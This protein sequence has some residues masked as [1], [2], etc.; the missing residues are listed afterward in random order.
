MSGSTV[1]VG[2]PV[3]TVG[4]NLYQGAVYVY[5]Q[6]ASGWSGLMTPS[7]ELTASDGTARDDFGSSVAA[8]GNTIAAKGQSPNA[9]AVYVFA[10]PAAGWSGSLTQSA[11]LGASNGAATDVFGD[12]V[13]VSGATV[14][15]GAPGH[16]RLGST[17]SGQGAAYVF[18]CPALQLPL[19]TRPP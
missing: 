10:Q 18:T 19:V 6:P 11:E 1:A 13:A 12:A 9:N 15:V 3:Q 5:T 16:H 14:I 2:A 17:G 8:S 4:S 7:A